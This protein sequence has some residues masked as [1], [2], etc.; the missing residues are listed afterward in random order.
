MRW[1][2]HKFHNTIRSLRLKIDKKEQNLWV[3]NI[4]TRYPNDYSC[5]SLG[6]AGLKYV[7]RNFGYPMMKETTQTQ[8]A[9]SLGLTDVCIRLIDAVCK[10]KMEWYGTKEAAQILYRMRKAQDINLTEKNII[11]PDAY[12]VMG[13]KNYWIEYDNCT[14]G[15]KRIEEKLMDYV[16]HLYALSSFWKDPT[17]KRHSPINRSPV[18]WITTQFQ[19]KRYLESIWNQMIQLRLYE[20]WIPEMLF[21]VQ[22]DETAYLLNCSQSE[23]L[24]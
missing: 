24:Q 22:S 5:Y 1:N 7:S 21:F 16:T 3:K 4:K 20:I 6:N 8:S 13:Q 19:R 14:E 17:G 15:T 10:E 12:L 11:R 2:H 9:H 23:T 18:I